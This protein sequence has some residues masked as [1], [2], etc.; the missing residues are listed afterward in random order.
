VLELEKVV[1]DAAVAV[2]VPP[3]RRR[4]SLA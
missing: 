3:A 2:K 4:A 1:R